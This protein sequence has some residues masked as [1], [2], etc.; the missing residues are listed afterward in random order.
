VGDPAC[1]LMIALTF[2][3]GAAR[4][5]FRKAMAM[6]EATWARARGWALSKALILLAPEL[7]APSAS[8]EPMRV[9]GEVFSDKCDP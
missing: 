1:D 2:F 8:L 9:L 5:A 4:E 6:S 7:D 3:N